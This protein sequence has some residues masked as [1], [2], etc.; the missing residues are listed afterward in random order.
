MPHVNIKHFPKH[1]TDQQKRGLIDA[2][3]LTI[4]RSFGCDE[5][6]ISVALEPIEEEDWNVRVYEPEIVG[7]SELLCKT[8]SY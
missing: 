3:T 5:G 1:L 7:R 6:A 4:Q 8:P 2:I